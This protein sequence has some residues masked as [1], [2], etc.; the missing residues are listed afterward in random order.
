[1]GAPSWAVGA[2]EHAPAADQHMPSAPDHR[3]PSTSGQGTRSTSELS[4]PLTSG[5]DTRS[6]S[7]RRTPKS[8]HLRCHPK[9]RLDSCM[10][11]TSDS[12][13]SS[14]DSEMSSST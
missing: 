3:M 1:M 5:Q 13:D 12:E 8:S 4:T 7:D 14:F 6:P 11:E 2:F 9:R 10:L